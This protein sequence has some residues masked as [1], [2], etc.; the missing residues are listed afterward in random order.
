MKST[1]KGAAESAIVA[2][3]AR[4]EAGTATPEEIHIL[5]QMLEKYHTPAV[6]QEEEKRDLP[7][8]GLISPEEVAVMM[9]RKN[10]KK[11]CV[12]L[13]KKV[14]EEGFPAPFRWERPYRWLAQDVKAYIEVQSDARRAAR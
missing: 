10:M 2:Y 13:I 1:E 4:I 14:K 7:Q 12:M 5:P 8:F 11:P 9:G 6:R 3:F